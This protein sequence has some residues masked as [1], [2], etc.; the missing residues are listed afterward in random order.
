[1]LAFV[2]IGSTRFDA[3]ITSVFAEPFLS[4]L[5]RKGYTNLI[6]QCGNSDFE[7]SSLIKNGETRS[8][9]KAG[10]EIEFWKF[11]PSLEDIFQKAD[12]V[13]GHSGDS[14]EIRPVGEDG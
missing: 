6:V 3:L 13:I 9:S 8:L 4:A 5:L 1:M 10:V 12:L 7:Q 11:R 14:R 2:T